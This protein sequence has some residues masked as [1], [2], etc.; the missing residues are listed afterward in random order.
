MLNDKGRNKNSIL[1]DLISQTRVRLKGN[2]EKW[3]VSLGL[4]FI[5]TFC[6]PCIFYNE[7]VLFNE[8]KR[9]KE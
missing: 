6:A 2:I 3:R 1:C 9:H 7:H 8:P 4:D 5:Y